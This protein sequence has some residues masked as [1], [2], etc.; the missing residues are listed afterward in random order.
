MKHR[1][2]PLKYFRG[3]EET[4]YKINQDLKKQQKIGK[5]KPDENWENR[6]A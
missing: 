5:K 1:F 2:G 4:E 6:S 3:N